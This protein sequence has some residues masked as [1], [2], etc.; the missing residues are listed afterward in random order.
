[1]PP[2]INPDEKAERIEEVLPKIHDLLSACRLCGRRCGIDRRTPHVSYCVPTDPLPMEELRFASDTLHHGEEPMLVGK[3]GSGAVFFTHCNL[4]CVFC[5]NFQI[6]QEGLGDRY[7]FDELAD[8]FLILQDRGAENI[9]LVTPTHYIYTILLALREAYADGL[10]IPLVYNTNGY[11]SLELI[12]LLDGI[13]DIYLPDLKYMDPCFA[14]RYSGARNYPETAQA[15]IKEMYQQ[16]GPVQLHKGVAKQGLIIRH[17]I[18]PN[19]LSN[20][21]DFLLWLKHEGLIEATVGLMSQYAPR[22]RA[23][24]F[25]ELNQT[26]SNEEYAEIVRYAVELGFENILAQ[27]LDSADVYFPDFENDIPF[28]EK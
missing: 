3:G 22:H 13:V 14:E 25:P 19:N 26:V 12:T 15:A 10:H 9:N 20:T 27:G 24:T 2:R 7:T 23:E 11:D 5:Q 16:V 1:M 28:S 4:R 18:L 21:Y 17:L 8:V 6:S